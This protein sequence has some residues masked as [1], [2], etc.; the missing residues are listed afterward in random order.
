MAHQQL[1]QRLEGTRSNDVI[2][3]GQEKKRQKCDKQDNISLCLMQQ[4]QRQQ[5]GSEPSYTSLNSNKNLYK[6]MHVFGKMHSYTRL[7]SY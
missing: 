6:H 5:S 3:R 2:K 4:Q 7:S 1:R